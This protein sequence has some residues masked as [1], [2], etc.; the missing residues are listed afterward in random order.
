MDAKTF[1]CKT[2]VKGLT[3]L[4]I[5]LMLST[6]GQSAGIPSPS[7]LSDLTLT[8]A[9]GFSVTLNAQ[10]L[11][12]LRLQNE[13]YTFSN[14]API[15]LTLTE[16]TE[17]STT[18]TLRVQHP[19]FRAEHIACGD[20]QATP[21]GL[22]SAMVFWRQCT[23][24]TSQAVLPGSF[25]LRFDFNVLE[26][27]NA[28][29]LHVTLLRS[30]L[31]FGIESMAYTAQLS[32]T[33]TPETV[34]LGMN[35]AILIQPEQMNPAHWPAF[36][37]QL[38][39]RGSWGD[40]QR[41]YLT[42]RITSTP[43]IG[44]LLDARRQTN[45]LIMRDT[46]ADPNTLEPDI[47]LLGYN[48]VENTPGYQMGFG[49]HALLANDNRPGN[50]GQTL[51]LGA[52]LKI[53][54][55]SRSQHHEP[56][57]DAM[58]AVKTNTEALFQNRDPRQDRTL[59]DACV[60]TSVYVESYG[61]ALVQPILDHVERIFKFYPNVPGVCI[62]LWGATVDGTSY[63]FLP[64]LSDLLDGLTAIEKTYGKPVRKSYYYLHSAVTGVN[65]PAARQ[66]DL[67]KD[68][69]GNAVCWT[70]EG[71][72]YCPTDVIR[73][74][75]FF[76]TWLHERLQPLDPAGVY[77]DDGSHGRWGINSNYNSEKLV[78]GHTREVAGAYLQAIQDT[79]AMFAAGSGG[80]LAIEGGWVAKDLP[81]SVIQGAGSAFE[82]GPFLDGDFELP[83]LVNFLVGG[84]FVVGFAGSITNSWMNF[85]D[86]S[87]IYYLATTA[88]EGR[89]IFHTAI[90]GP[91]GLRDISEACALV[92]HLCEDNP[93]YLHLP[94]YAR[95]LNKTMGF[96]YEKSRHEI[97]STWDRTFPPQN[98]IG[99]DY[100]S[101][102]SPRPFRVKVKEISAGYFRNPR[103]SDE[104]AFG[105]ANP[106]AQTRALTLLLNREAY[107]LPTHLAYRITV[108]SSDDTEPQTFNIEP[109]ADLQVSFK[110][111]SQEL[112]MLR[113]T[114]VTPPN[115]PQGQSPAKQNGEPTQSAQLPENA[116]TFN[117]AAANNLSNAASSGTTGAIGCQ[118]QPGRCSYGDLAWL[119]GLLILRFLGI[120]RR[121]HRPSSQATGIL[122]PT[123]LPTNSP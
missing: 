26:N 2:F 96:V 81:G 15:A 34:L 4:S 32:P 1:R 75:D 94:G 89:M 7:Q 58:I 46:T 5:T 65:Y 67:T 8:N 6:A 66:A 64:N 35:E 23:L 114:P 104:L 120:G 71:S 122:R 116:Q 11:L 41:Q 111:R 73:S 45:L 77:F 38:A 90:Q 69:A 72:F 16:V 62:L 27:E 30:T 18:K 119:F 57:W 37:P 47:G 101:Y 17:D 39:S 52:G 19:L 3:F 63:E 87:K 43:L 28:L 115:S 21:S 51:P 108:E 112:M 50:G 82:I 31:P 103:N 107:Q 95:L 105:F 29:T 13:T 99:D 12:H 84:K 78:Q 83:G 102:I 91:T 70:L 61:K 110:I 74:M 92:A 86:L 76:Q 98:N 106:Q 56:L 33:E 42:T 25:D 80:M 53:H 100:I 22:T 60:I 54:M 40:G 36:D 113:F 49:T 55:L 79:H 85:A 68:A 48:A 88:I 93:V 20:R 14:H 118:T 117:P 44:A 59:D 121:S 10:Q 109:G 123:H 24:T 97:F 9:R